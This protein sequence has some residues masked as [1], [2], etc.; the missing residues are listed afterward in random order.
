MHCSTACSKHCSAALADRRMSHHA[1]L[2]LWSLSQPEAGAVE[3]EADDADVDRD[4][5]RG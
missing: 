5:E 3:R 2:E 1:A 4:R